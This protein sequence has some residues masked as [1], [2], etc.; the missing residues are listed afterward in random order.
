MMS[1]S[2]RILFMLLLVP[3]VGQALQSEPCVDVLIPEGMP[4]KIWAERDLTESD[5][6]KYIV[7]RE[8]AGDALQAKIT[9]VMLDENGTIKFKRSRE[10]GRLNDQMSIA[11]ADKNV[12]RI[13]IIVDW[14][15]TNRGRWVPNTKTQEMDLEQLIKHGTKALPK[16]KFIRNEQAKSG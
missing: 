9:T 1:R 14:L 13:L 4:I 8:V 6:L 11:A 10:G 2:L 3:L 5:I 7:T 15:E 16:A 12:S